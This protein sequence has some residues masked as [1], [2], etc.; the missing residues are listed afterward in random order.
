[1]GMC[2]GCKEV[3]QSDLMVNGYC[4][5]CIEKGSKTHIVDKEKALRIE[6][7]KNN[8]NLSES[9]YLTTETS[10]NTP[11]EKRL[12]IVSSQCVYGI[13]IVKDMFSFFKDI[14]GGRIKSLEDALEESNKEILNDLKKKAY[15]EGGNAVIGIKIE[16]TY[17]NANNG[18]ILSVFA[19]GT[20]VKI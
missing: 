15:L 16:H 7:L 20:V 18:S 1:M 2:K 11:I 6:E 9:I 14:I 19:T 17:N 12:C 3:F 4:S 10:I 8:K 13:N 5:D